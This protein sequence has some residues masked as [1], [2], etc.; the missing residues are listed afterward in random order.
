MWNASPKM[1]LDNYINNYQRF[2]KLPEMRMLYHLGYWDGPLSGICLIDGQKY[3]FECIEEW[4]DNN[5]WPD[6]NDPA[7]ED[8]EPPWYRRYLI[9]KLTDDNLAE[10]EARHQKWQRM[11]GMHCDYDE[12]GARKFFHYTETITPE[13]VRQYYEDAAKLPKLDLTPNEDQIIGWHELV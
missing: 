12:N 7:Y 6:E 2:P 11:V 5:K 10:I 4:R 13:T 3:W 8:F 1:I 9:W